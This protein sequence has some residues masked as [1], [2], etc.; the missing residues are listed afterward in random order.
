MVE[1]VGLQGALTNQQDAWRARS[2]AS[3]MAL[4]VRSPSIPISFLH[5]AATRPL[6]CPGQQ[7]AS[8][9]QQLPPSLAP[10][11]TVGRVR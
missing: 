7:L 11:W 3:V 10:S 6:V 8:V 9:W 5:L 1:A 2:L 4:L